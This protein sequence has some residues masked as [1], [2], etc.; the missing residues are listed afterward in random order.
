[1]LLFFGSLGYSLRQENKVATMIEKEML[2]RRGV[3][4]GGF[5]TD[6]TTTTGQ[7]AAS[8]AGAAEYRAEVTEGAMPAKSQAK[9]RVTGIE[10]T[11]SF[12]GAVGGPIREIGVST[13]SA[14]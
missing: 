13:K 6:Y 9:E 7:G 4:F 8:V 10:T 11:T 3:L 14:I 2:R 12:E 1:M 5:G